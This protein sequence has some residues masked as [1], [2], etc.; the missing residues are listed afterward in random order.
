MVVKTPDR[1]PSELTI[2]LV[3]KYLSFP[4]EKNGIIS[5]PKTQTGETN[6]ILCAAYPTGRTSHSLARKPLTDS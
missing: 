3:L 2:G 1:Q 5:T 6:R 4:L